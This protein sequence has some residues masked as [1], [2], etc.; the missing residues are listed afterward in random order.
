MKN[1][2]NKHI[3][4]GVTGGI[5]AYKS[6]ELLRLLTRQGAQVQV[7]MS[8]AASDF[9]T[10]L[11]L[12]A[13]SGRPVYQHWEQVEAAMGHIQL[14]RWADRILLAPATA[15]SLARLAQGRA[16]QLLDALCLASEAELLV[17]PAMNRV[18]WRDKATR[19]NVEVLTA[20]GI[21][22]LGPA[23]GEQACGETGQGRMLEAEQLCRLLA[24]SFS[25]DLLAGVNVLVTAGPTQ[26]PIDPVRCLTNHSSGKTGYAI[27]AAARLA[28]AAVTLV[29]GPVNEAAPDKVDIVQVMTAAQMHTAVMQRIDQQNV[30]IATA[31]VADYRPVTT[32]DHKIKKQAD[33]LTLE[34][35][36]TEDI[37][38]GV[39]ALDDAPLCVGFAAETENLE[40]NARQK[41]HNKSLDLIVANLVGEGLGFGVATNAWHLF[42]QD[43]DIEIPEQSKQKLAAQLIQRIA[44]LL[45][46]N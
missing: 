18:M 15:D 4:L 19:K 32:A 45:R 30:F 36:R 7:V 5:A 34:L 10:P 38:A 25:S 29:S 12:Q 23:S 8:L 46:T 43:G 21:Q 24:D 13:L 16:D 11:T 3:L 35:E 20:R 27:A 31:A 26:E 6:A 37:L 1:L 9:V 41:L 14:A 28:G 44:A 33:S 22:I 17:A 39:A 42:W 2:N 40:D